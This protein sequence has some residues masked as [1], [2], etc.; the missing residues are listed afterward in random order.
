MRLTLDG[1]DGGPKKARFEGTTTYRN[2]TWDGRITGEAKQAGYLQAHI[3]A[4]VIGFDGQTK[5]VSEDGIYYRMTKKQVADGIK[6]Y[7]DEHM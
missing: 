3:F 7:R 6:R 2:G 5:D 1:G 4:K